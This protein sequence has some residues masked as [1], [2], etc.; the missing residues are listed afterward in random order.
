M[1]WSII[2]DSSC[3][4]PA[5][6]FQDMNFHFA[7]V[8]LKI[9]VG[10]TE[11]VDNDEMNVNTMLAQMKN[12]SGPSSSA[13]PAPE[14]WA[15]EFRKSDAT[16]A[17]TMT[18]ALSGTYNS[19][20]IAKNIVEEEYPE[21]RIHVLD[22]RSTAGGLVLILRYA[23]ELVQQGRPFDAV[24][25]QAEQYARGLSLLFTPGSFDNLIKNGRM[26]RVAGLLAGA[27]GIR[28]VASNTA[29]GTIRI[30][31]KTRGEDRVFRTMVET[32]QSRKDLKGQP[33]VITHCNNPE[34][35]QKLKELIA[36]TCLT[37]KISVMHTRGLT[38]FY[39]ENGGIL[40]GF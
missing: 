37:T 23:A 22:S 27:L 33:V 25:E 19:A 28:A 18:S 30:L 6:A 31:Q 38:S 13:C 40:V 5:R 7:T 8:P 15:H 20:L 11:Y 12:Y 36:H 17:V 34:G 32:M 26:S 4:L 14:E 39:T 35:A 24:V 10:A 3:D 9:V 29:E 16:L 1:T 2:S 21:K